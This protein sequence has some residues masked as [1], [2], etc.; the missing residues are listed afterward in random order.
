M[1]SLFFKYA[2]CFVL[3]GCIFSFTA[4][5][6]QNTGS[7]TPTPFIPTPVASPTPFVTDT[8]EPTPTISPTPKPSVITAKPKPKVTAAPVSTTPIRAVPAAIKVTTTRA[9][10]EN[11]PA[12]HF[13]YPGT[14]H[15]V[16]SNEVGHDGIYGTVFP[17]TTV[18]GD[19]TDV[20]IIK[21]HLVSAWGRGIKTGVNTET[22]LIREGTIYN[23]YE[24]PVLLRI[25]VEVTVTD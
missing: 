14:H 2:F 18:E 1:A 5:A 11:L 17:G 21:V 9:Q 8:P 16:V 6:Q 23:Q 15:I 7:L 13:Y 12:F 19:M 22:F 25:P 20:A 24:K 10:L 4:C 3:T